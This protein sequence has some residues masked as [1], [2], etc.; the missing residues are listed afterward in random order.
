MQ[1][2]EVIRLFA[3]DNLLIDPIENLAKQTGE[4]MARPMAEPRHRFLTP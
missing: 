4:K 3:R 1:R 2:K